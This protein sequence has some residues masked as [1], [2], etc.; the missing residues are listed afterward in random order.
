MDQSQGS[1]GKT[2]TILVDNL[3][4]GVG[5]RRLLSALNVSKSDILKIDW[6][7]DPKRM[8]FKGYAHVS[9]WSF[10]VAEA[11]AL[12][13]GEMCMDRPLKI[14]MAP[15]REDIQQHPGAPDGREGAG[16]G[17]VSPAKSFYVSSLKPANCRTVFVG[18][19]AYNITGAIL[20][21]FFADCGPIVAVR[22]GEVAGEFKGFAHVVFHLS[23]STDWAVNKS[24]AILLGRRTKVDYG[25]ES[26]KQR[27]QGKQ[28][29]SLK[30]PGCRTV[31]VGHL[32]MSTDES[33]V[34]AFFSACGAVTR[35]RLA[36]DRC[37]AA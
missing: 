19:L 32:P 6:G 8:I 15:D 31:F 35:V 37:L 22:W 7:L 23:D 21:A 30:P 17:D 1:V 28:V 3:D 13:S 36:A 4:Y 10:S 5:E 11:A 2:R 9:F 16:P 12:R 26:K 29:R 34:R 24:G 33:E 25:Q 27:L 14:S 20:R 18:N